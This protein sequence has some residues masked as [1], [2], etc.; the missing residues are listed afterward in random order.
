MRSIRLLT[1][2]TVILAGVW[3][4]GGDGGGDTGATDDPSAAFTPPACVAGSPCT[5]TDASSDPQGA[6]TITTRVWDFGDQTGPVT[7]TGV[8]QDHTFQ[9]AGSFGV[10]LTV[11]DNT[12]KS[13]DVTNQ[14]TVTAPV[15]PPPTAAFTVPAC[16]VG[17]ACLFSDLSSPRQGG[18]LVSWSWNF[19]DNT[20]PPEQ[21]QQNPSHTFTTA[22]IY[23][24][25]LTVTDDLGTTGTTTQSVTV[26]DVAATNCTTSGN[27]ATC[28]L[29]ITQT[30]T[31]LI[32][33]ASRACQLVGNNVRVDQPNGQF[34]FNN[35][36]RGPAPG[37]YGIVNKD[38]GLPAVFQAGTQL[39]IIF[40]QGQVTDPLTDPPV[41]PPAARLSGSSTAGWIINIDDGGNTGQAGEPDFDDLVL[42][43]QASPAS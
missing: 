43:V 25:T 12:G 14:V 36:C 27:S 17:V 29:D 26:S 34:V 31:V 38:T 5:F 42:Q 39:R 35:A 21:S 1:A 28:T 19:G 15:S 4:C 33:L 9:A 10:K 13:D 18:S 41:G 32:T 22:G 40:V 8:T 11:T 2:T 24:V 23:Q 30:S 6:G 20:T 16:T 3:A 7:A 37:P